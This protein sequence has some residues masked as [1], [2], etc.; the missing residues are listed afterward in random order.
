MEYGILVVS[1]SYHFVW[2]YVHEQPK[3]RTKKKKNLKHDKVCA[4]IRYIIKQPLTTFSK[5]KLQTQ[6]E[7]RTVN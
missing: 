1:V 4:N 2:S 7:T 3:T 5:N 6:R